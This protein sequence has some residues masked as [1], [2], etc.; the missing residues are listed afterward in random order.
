MANMNIRTPRFYIDYIQYLLSRGVAQNGNFDVIGTGGSGATATRGLQSGTEAEL[1][2]GRPLNLCSF[3]TSGAQDSRVLI[4]ANMQSASPKQ[5][6][7]A[8]LNHNLKSADGKIRLFAGDEATDVATVNG[9]AA[10]TSDINWNTGATVTNVI[11]AENGDVAGDNKSYAVKPDADGTSII[12][13]NEMDLRY[14]G[15]QFEGTTNETDVGAVDGLWD[16]STDFTVGGI[17]IGEIYEMPHSPDMDLTRSIVFDKIKMQESLGGQRYGTMANHG[18]TGSSTSKSPFTTSSSNRHLYGGR[19]T[20][21]MNFS[22]LASTH[23]MPDEYH[24]KD[25]DD[26]AVVEDI[27]NLTNGPLLPFIFSCDKDSEGSNAQSEH[28]FARFAQNSLEMNQVANDMYN[29]NMKIEEEF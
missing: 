6:F 3:D 27:W 7:I 4:T 28:I 25:H 23:L 15:I 20:Y 21:E 18:R 26:D 9:G 14:W 10:D 17:M 19:L 29:I 8:V 12:K 2:D 24:I 16:A 11:N 1:F 5:S 13:I 22:Y